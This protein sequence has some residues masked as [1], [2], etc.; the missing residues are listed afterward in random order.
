MKRSSIRINPSSFYCAF[1]YPDKKNIEITRR[2][3]R[4]GEDIQNEDLKT[5]KAISVIKWNKDIVYDNYLLLDMLR[6]M[7]KSLGNKIE[8]ERISVIPTNVKK[9][10]QFVL[11]DHLHAHRGNKSGYSVAT[12]FTTQA[13]DVTQN[14]D[15]PIHMEISL[16]ESVDLLNM[17][18]C[19]LDITFFPIYDA[20][21]DEILDS[22]RKN[23]DGFTAKYNYS[24]EDYSSLKLDSLFFGT[25]ATG[26]SH[27]EIP[28][29]YRLTEDGM[30]III[31]DKMG[32]LAALGLYVITSM[33]DKIY[34]KALKSGLEAEKIERNKET[35]IKNLTEP[36]VHLGKAISKFLPN[37]EE[38]F[39]IA[40]NILVSYPISK[41]GISALRELSN[42]I[43]REITINE[44][45]LFDKDTTRF[46]EDENLVSNVTASTPNTNIIIASKEISTTIIEELSKIRL[47]PMVIGSVGKSGKTGI[48]FSNN[49]NKL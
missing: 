7:S 23:I 31:T 39:D 41:N 14:I 45:P 1:P 24:F 6:N 25:T 37:F 12:N 20:P 29:K 11:F 10:Y 8:I 33:D 43:N 42:L 4:F 18:G 46:L 5:K 9:D 22:I 34:E 17:L 27:K 40:S 28:D 44:I 36:K 48:S 21:N 35:A 13:T 30:Q 16:T 3:Y 32:L 38:P 2:I 49:R 19:N 26:N 47:N 15:S